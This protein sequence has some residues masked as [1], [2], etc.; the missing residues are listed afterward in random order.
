MKINIRILIILST[1]S[2]LTICLLTSLMHF[3]YHLTRTNL[4]NER[5]NVSIDGLNRTLTNN[6]KLGIALQSLQ[7]VEGIIKHIKEQ[8]KII[9]R[10]E[11]FKIEEGKLNT[12]FQTDKETIQDNINTLAMQKIKG[13][14]GINWFFSS[15]NGL[16]YVGLTLRD[17][18]GL[19]RNAIM[20]SYKTSFVKAQE[21]EEV[22]SLYKRM[23]FGILASIIASFFIARRSTKNI[24]QMLDVITTSFDKLE[25]NEKK[26]DLSGIQDPIVRGNL[27][28]MITSVLSARQSLKG[29]ETLLISADKNTPSGKNKK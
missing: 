28:A 13:S 4:V 16:T 12:L 26:F 27:R 14:K 22:M 17:P 25:R 11:I 18:T 23:L 5:L 7:N 15:E 20:L 6:I 8:D 24:A 19:D 10:I 3:R 2:V 21:H 9:E 1:I 29:I